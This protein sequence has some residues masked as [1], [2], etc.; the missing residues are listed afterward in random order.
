MAEKKEF[1]STEIPSVI[2]GAV[3]YDPKVITIWDGFKEYFEEK[4]LSFDYVLY[5]NY[6]AQVEAHFRGDFNV[7]W[8]SPLAWLQ[9]ERIAQK[10]GKKVQSVVMRDSDQ[11]LRS[12]VVVPEGSSIRSL[13]DL[14]GKKIGVGAHDSPQATLIPLEALAKQGLDADKDFTVVYHDKL[15]GK[16]G[17]HIG[18]ERDAARAL[19]SQEIDACCVLDAN[20]LLFAQE[21]T[22]QSGDVRVLHRTELFDHCNFT[23]IEGDSLPVDRFVKILLDM[24]YE[25]PTCRRLFDLEGLKAWKVGR[26]SAYTSLNDSLARFGVVDAWID[27]VLSRLRT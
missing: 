2:L 5:S 20:Y 9:A 12:F 19:M 6:E 21:G 17:D 11:D 15:V 26:S 22:Y 7:A 1:L 10:L 27:A 24:S 8:N 25:D 23:V 3:A 18:G 14:K 16:H 13:E 4:G